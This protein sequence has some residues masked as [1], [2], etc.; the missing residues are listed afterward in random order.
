VLVWNGLGSSKY[1]TRDIVKDSIQNSFCPD[2][3]IKGPI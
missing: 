1:V 3:V 2:A